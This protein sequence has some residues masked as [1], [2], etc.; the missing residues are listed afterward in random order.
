MKC[1]DKY[2]YLKIADRMEYQMGLNSIT[3]HRIVSKMYCTNVYMYRRI[4]L[5]IQKIAIQI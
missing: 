2:K 5:Y 4:D 3:S 1:M